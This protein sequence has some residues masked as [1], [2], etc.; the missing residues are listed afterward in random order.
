MNRTPPE[1]STEYSRGDAISGG[2]LEP[3]AGA[4]PTGPEGA[5]EG[6][7]RLATGLL[8]TAALGALLLLVAEFTT[9]FTVHVS[10]TSK[11]LESVSGGSHHS[12][13]MALIALS[14]GILAV[15]VWRGGSRPALLGIGLLGVVA[16]LIGLLGDLHD[17]TASGLIL[18][19]SHF[20]QA[21]STPGAGFFIEI[22]GA[23][24]L[25][26]ACVWGFLLTAPPRPPRRPT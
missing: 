23:L 14:A 17:A 15:A 7:G 1:A 12:Y 9:L 4:D 13:A 22:L 21:S 11:P 5:S 16:L 6:S 8:A 2:R 19:S 3:P 10:N 24:L 18:T 25:V 26:I 20:I